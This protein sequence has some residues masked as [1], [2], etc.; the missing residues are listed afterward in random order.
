MKF[1]IGYLILFAW[2][3]SP[4]LAGQVAYGEVRYLATRLNPADDSLLVDEMPDAIATAL[5]EMMRGGGFDQHYVLTFTPEAYTFWELPRDDKTVEDG[6]ITMRVM[7]TGTPD[8]YHTDM[9]TGEFTAVRTVADRPFY[10]ADRVRAPDWTLTGER[11]AASEATLGFDL[12]VAT[13]LTPE[14]DS[15][16]AA[17]APAIPIPFGPTNVYGLPG[18]VLQLDVCAGEKCKRYQATSFKIL[19]DAPELQKPIGTKAVSQAEYNRQKAKYEAR[20]RKIITR[21]FHD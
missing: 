19:S 11:I 5:R 18:A 20:T 4:P 15:L 17:Y 10:I 16:R 14:G 8:A 1:S 21:E 12:R 3:I 2:L 13:A 7:G 9:Q 6:G